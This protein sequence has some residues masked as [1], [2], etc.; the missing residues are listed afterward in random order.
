MAD[1]KE[2]VT[3][4]SRVLDQNSIFTDFIDEFFG[5]VMPT[6]WVETNDYPKVNIIDRSTE[7]KKIIDIEMAVAGFNEDEIKAYTE[8]GVL[9]VEGKQMMKNLPDNYKYISKGI[10]SRDFIW[11]RTLPKYGEATESHLKNG[12][13]SIRVEVNIPEEKKKKILKIGKE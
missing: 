3:R 2:I 13:L 4:L 11:K 9:I 1:S 10:A 5:D 12:V 6:A 7:D 8:D